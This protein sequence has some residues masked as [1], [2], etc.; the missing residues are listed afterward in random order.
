MNLKT[1]LKTSNQN[2]LHLFAAVFVFGSLWGLSEVVLGGSLRT[3]NFPYR[4]G[5]LTGLGMGIMG[6]SLAVTRKW[7]LPVGIGVIAALATLLVVPVLHASPMCR[8]NSCLALGLESGSLALVSLIIGKKIG[9]NVYGLMGIGAGAA[10]LAS[11]AFY[12]SGVHLA[13][14]AFLLSF[15][16]GSFIVKEGLVWAAFSSVLLPVGYAAGEWLAVKSFAMR[17]ESNA[18]YYGSSTAI[19]AICWGISALAISAGF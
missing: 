17:I 1:V 19:V 12:F 14:C 3:A 8:A 9:G 6:A 5:L 15:T 10:M 16:P 2:L 18:Y 7:F 11:V 13:P 4:S